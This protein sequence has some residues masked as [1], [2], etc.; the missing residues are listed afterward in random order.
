MTQ[1]RGSLFADDA[2]FEAE[3]RRLARFVWTEGRVQRSP[4]ID[5]HERDAL[6][7]TNDIVIVIE[8]TTSRKSEK[9][10]NDSKKTSELIKK[11]R[12]QGF[13]ARGVIVTKDD[14]TAEQE[15]IISSGKYRG[16]I[17]LL[18]YR[19]L[20]TRLFDVSEYFLA[21]NT[22]PFGSIQ[23]PRN[24][25]EVLD[26]SYFVDVPLIE[27]ATGQAYG[28][29][30][31]AETLRSR[32][33][34]WIVVADFGSGKSMTLRE[35]FYTLQESFNKR[36]H[37]RFPLYI[38]LRDHSGAKYPAEILE[39]HGRDLGL[40]DHTSLV[41]AWQAG[42]TDLILDGFDEFTV[43]AWTSN[44]IKLRQVRQG[45][46]KA[47]RDLITRSPPETGIVLCGRLYY[48][49]S[50]G[51]MQEAL[52]AGDGWRLVRIHPLTDSYAM[53]IVKRYGRDDYNVPDWVPSRALLL[54]YLAAR[55]FLAAT[56]SPSSKVNP[57]GEG[58]D[59]LLQM[60][61]AREAQQHPGLVPSK[62]LL[63]IERLA[64]AARRTSDALGSFS[65][66]NMASI[67][68]QTCDFAP[69]DSARS[70]MSRLPALAGTAAE[71]GHRR[72]IDPDIADAARAGDL[73]RFIASP[74]SQELIVAFEDAM[75]QRSVSSNCIDRLSFLIEREAVPEAKVTF[76]LEQ[77]SRRNWGM[78]AVDILQL[79]FL[80]G[81]DYHGNL[82]TISDAHFDGLVLD[83]ESPDLSRVVFYGCIVDSLHLDRNASIEK[84]PQFRGC[85]IQSLDGVVTREDLPPAVFRECEIETLT[86]SV[87]RN[88]SILDTDLPLG[89]KVLLTTLNKLFIQAGGGRRENAFSRGLDPR[90]RDLVPSILQL[91]ERHNFAMQTK[92]KGQVIWFPRRDKARR[93]RRILEQPAIGDDQLLVEVRKM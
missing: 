55:D 1:A 25:L 19:D 88:A 76:A 34:R 75:P 7:E 20:L 60:I 82:I 70:L 74:Y 59:A 43:A 64:T 77:A 5:G 15:K 22:Q 38:N 50:I 72:F 93:V 87:A 41:K 79:M 80:L 42:L 2:H 54:S 56:S 52:G 47:V 89:T 3:V 28:A 4:I 14:P 84:S 40:R 45:A 10:E 71:S 68:E 26:R 58:W 73:A 18:S 27:E 24:S 29:R 57:R 92:L 65:E 32:S 11:I 8:A 67:F 37:S 21:R 48:F 39:R 12:Q 44:R 13:A 17:E 36:M 46:L 86:N 51:E 23:N 78:I 81:I 66:S 9:I 91:V 90:A 63:F 83:A 53:Q 30:K 16:A 69:D 33:S 31:I 62:V 61:A 49:D 6:I 85:L 35:I